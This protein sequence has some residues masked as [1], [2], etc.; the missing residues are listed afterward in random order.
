MQSACS[1]R[2]RLVECFFLIELDYL[3]GRDK[4]MMAEEKEGGGA[5]VE[6]VSAMVHVKEE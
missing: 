3:R 6:S 5:G 1:G 2:A 4:L